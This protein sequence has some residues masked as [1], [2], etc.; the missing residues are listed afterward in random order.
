MTRPAP[1]FA[2]RRRCRADGT[3]YL[4]AI[5]NEDVHLVAG[6]ELHLRRI[7][8]DDSEAFDGATHA[9]QIL[10][11]RRPWSD[12]P[13]ARRERAA[14]DRLDGSALRHDPRDAVGEEAPW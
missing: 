3:P 10:P 2:M 12:E 1:T 8:G 5:L 11:P 7:T 4:M 14:C 13:R 9:L 6:S